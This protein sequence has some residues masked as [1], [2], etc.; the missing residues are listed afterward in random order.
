MSLSRE[1]GQALLATPLQVSP[2]LR[3]SFLAPLHVLGA[4]VF[5]CMPSRSHACLLSWVYGVRCVCTVGWRGGG[6]SVCS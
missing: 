2:P 3:P 1:E 4:L 6:F 5:L